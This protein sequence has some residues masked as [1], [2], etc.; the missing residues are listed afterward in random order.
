VNTDAYKQVI[1]IRTDLKMG[2]GKMVAQGAH[3]AVR[4]ALAHPNDKRVKAWANEGMTKICVKIE[5]DVEL[6]LLIHEAS[7]A[8]LLA[9]QIKDAG[10][11]EF[12]GVPTVTC[13]AIGPD[14]NEK[15]D[16]F[17]SGLKLL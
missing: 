16:Q 8:G 5:S 3:A 11:T 9:T 13:G 17:T 12:H 4:I 1:I 10:Y 15:V 6:Q 7:R 14:L 2:K